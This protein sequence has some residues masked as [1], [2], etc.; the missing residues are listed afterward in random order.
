MV[1]TL[2]LSMVF[3]LPPSMVYTT[4]LV[5]LSRIPRLYSLI[6]SMDGRSKYGLI[7]Y[8]VDGNNAP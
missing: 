5:L 1:F 3:T 2:P 4:Y 6:Y 8:T 7:H